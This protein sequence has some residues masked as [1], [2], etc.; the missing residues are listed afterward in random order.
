MGSN[1]SPEKGGV[2]NLGAWAAKKQIAI[3]TIGEKLGLD[4]SARALPKARDPKVLELYRLQKIAASIK[5]QV[6]PGSKSI[7]IEDALERIR[8]TKGV[9]PALYEKIEQ[10]LKE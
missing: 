6:G 9:G 5:P 8:G 2:M 3:E 1:L 10:A 7:E 4:L